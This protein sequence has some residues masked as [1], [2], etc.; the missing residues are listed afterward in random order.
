[1]SFTYK[2]RNDK[3]YLYFQAGTKGTYY[4]SPKDLPSNVNIEN[5]KKSLDHM[6]QKIER[7][8]KIV[9][10]L[11]S[12]L[13]IDVRKKYFERMRKAVDNSFAH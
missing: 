4:L 6:M 3:E 2:K 13:P 1:M 7:D 8:H 12:Y 5:V 10:R 11:M 9:I